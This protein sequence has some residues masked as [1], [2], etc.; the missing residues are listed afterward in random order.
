MLSFDDFKKLDIRIGTIMSAQRIPDTEKLLKLLVDV[1]EGEPRH[2][3]AGIALYK[4]PE[5]LV[6]VQCPFVVNLEPKKLKGEESQGM[7]LAVGAKSLEGASEHEA[8]SVPAITL[9]HPEREVLP[10]STVR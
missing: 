9:L 8:E 6:G 3:I 10:G 4:A 5:D 2:I 1:G 7:L